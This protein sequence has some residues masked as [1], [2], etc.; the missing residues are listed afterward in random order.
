MPNLSNLD[1]SLPGLARKDL[2]PKPGVLKDQSVV[3]GAG[4]E[5]AAQLWKAAQDFEAMFLSQVLKQMRG[6]VHKE[7]L[8]HGGQGEDIFTEMMDEEFAQQ[9]AKGESTGIAGMLYKQLARQFGI[10][11][12]GVAPN[13]E[14]LPALS[15]PAGTEAVFS[16]E[17]G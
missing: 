2:G 1:L 5:K 7:K 6:T 12:S 10:E 8:F 14:G 16:W 11:E 17:G 4:D 3:N 9:M 15:G 13:P